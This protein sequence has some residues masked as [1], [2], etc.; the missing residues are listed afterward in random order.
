M[1][2]IDR[3]RSLGALRR[4]ERVTYISLVTLFEPG[5]KSKSRFSIQSYQV[6][7]VCFTGSV[8]SVNGLP[9][10]TP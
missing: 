10:A 4:L 2:I 8:S 5:P 9:F 6:R 1:E 7:V 3:P